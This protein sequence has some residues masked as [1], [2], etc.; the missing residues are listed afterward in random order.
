MVPAPA[1]MAA[2]PSTASPVSWNPA[3]PPPPVM[4]AAVGYT[5]GDGLY[6]GL[7][8]G[9]YD[10]LPLDEVFGL[11][12]PVSV[13]LPLAEEDGLEPLTDGESRLTLDEGDPELVQAET[14]TQASTVV[15]P[16]PMAVSLARC[17]VRAMAV[18]AFIGPPHARQ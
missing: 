13:A 17:A 10:G 12:L 18:R 14:A 1:T 11:W 9:L 2:P 8:E 3:V 4:G 7:Y 5:V 16:Q 6:E 15:R